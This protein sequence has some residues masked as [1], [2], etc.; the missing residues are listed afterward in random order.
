MEILEEFE[1][2]VDKFDGNLAHITLKTKDGEII[3]AEY[4]TSILLTKG[5]REHRRFKCSTV[6]VE[7]KVEL[8]FEAIP[9][10][11]VDEKALDKKLKELLMDFQ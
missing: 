4:P 5:I 1:G 11:E 8:K 10:C 3:W 2:F 7:G 6:E 9:D